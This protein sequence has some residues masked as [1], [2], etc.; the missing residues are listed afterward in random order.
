MR[1]IKPKPSRVARKA[2]AM[3]YITITTLVAVDN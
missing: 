2:Q 3:K 1:L